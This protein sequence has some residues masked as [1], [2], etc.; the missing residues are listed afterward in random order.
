MKKKEGVPINIKTIGILSLGEMGH[1]CAIL[2]RKKG[3]RVITVLNG[4]SERTR[5][6]AREAKVEVVDNLGLLVESCDLILSLVTPSSARAVCDA[7]GQAMVG[8]ENA[9]VFIDANPISPM[10]AETMAQRMKTIGRRFIDGAI[11]GSASEIGRSAALYLSG[12]GAEDLKA[13][14]EEYG[15]KVKVVGREIGQASALKV[16]NAGLNKGVAALL[17]ELLIGA[18]R[19]GILDV[20]VERYNEGFQGIVE[21][22]G[23][24]L[25]GLSIHARRRSEEMAELEATLRHAGTE[26]IVTPAIRELLSGIASLAPGFGKNRQDGC[27]AFLEEL[28]DKSFLSVPET[29]LRSME[30]S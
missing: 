25:A 3:A 19:A 6:L 24:F 30:P 22:M 7:V 18:S 11:I 4:R 17:V 26:P 23:G 12:P 16:F 9:P 27:R 20:V 29:G 1:A 10:T 5:A 15:L 21:K 8:R 13:I 2:F 28:L 14:E